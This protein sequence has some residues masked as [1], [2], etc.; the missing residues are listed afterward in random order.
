MLNVDKFL[1]VSHHIMSLAISYTKWLGLKTQST[2]KHK[3]TSSIQ[4][5]LQIKIF[6]EVTCLTCLMRVFPPKIDILIKNSAIAIMYR[7]IAIVRNNDP[8]W[9]QRYCVVR[10][11]MHCQTQ[12][13]R[14]LI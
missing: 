14:Y 3:A 9:W 5:L 12:R 10:N 8:R 2:E 4:S 1:F 11:Q 6:P 13:Y 7:G